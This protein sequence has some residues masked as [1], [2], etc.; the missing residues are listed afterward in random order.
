V[1]VALVVSVE[2][3]EHLGDQVVVEQVEEQHLMTLL[4]L[5]E[6]D[7][8]E[9]QTLVV[10]AVEVLVELTLVEMVVQELLY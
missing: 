7:K 10:E 9:Q 4:L 8:M 3:Q 2:L 5:Q 6:L 1:V